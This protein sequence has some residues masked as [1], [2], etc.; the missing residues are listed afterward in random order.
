MRLL[1]K[2]IERKEV[3]SEIEKLN[4]KLKDK[5]FSELFN[6]ELEDRRISKEDFKRHFNTNGWMLSVA[7]DKYYS[8][9]MIESGAT[10]EF[11]DLQW[12]Q[13]ITN[14][15]E[16]FQKNKIQQE[17]KTNNILTQFIKN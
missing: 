15:I 13:H 12:L 2:I 3:K 7:D 10:K 8:K 11:C 17:R 4:E 9:L 16:Y 1:V 6:K 5:K 14:R